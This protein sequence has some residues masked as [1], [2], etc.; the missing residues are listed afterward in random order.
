MDGGKMT[1]RSLL[2]KYR[3]TLVMVVLFVVFL[4]LFPSKAGRAEK[5]LLD[6][7]KTM[8]LVMPPIFVLLGLLDVWVPR[9]MLIRYMG[10]GSGVK[11]TALGIV[12]GAVA[13]G[14]LY[15]AFPVAAVLMDKGASFMNVL[16]FIG[17]WSTLKI[18]MFLFEMQSLGA[19]FAVAR[20]L[21]DVP[22]IFLIAFILNKL[23]TAE[24][25]EKIYSASHDAK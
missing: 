2:K 9:E 19:R 5:S 21:V 13:A 7:L 11:G 22:G 18:P 17:A 3:A 12:L 8:L 4:F 6:Q 16:V 14:P 20:F 23:L 25:V 24:D 1:F 10:K 15:G